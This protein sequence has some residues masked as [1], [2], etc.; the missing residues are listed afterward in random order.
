MPRLFNLRVTRFYLQMASEQ[1]RGEVLN[2]IRTAMRPPSV[3]FGQQLLNPSLRSFRLAFYKMLA[4]ELAL[5]I[6]KVMRSPVLVVEGIPD[7][8]ILVSARPR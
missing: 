7:V 2:L 6:E 8:I 5:C 1:N 4:T 3:P